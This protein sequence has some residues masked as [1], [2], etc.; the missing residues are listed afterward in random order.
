ME[1]DCKDSDSAGAKG[2]GQWCS[3]VG[4][5]AGAGW[6]AGKSRWDSFRGEQYLE[7]LE[8]LQEGQRPTERQE[9]RDAQSRLANEGRALHG[10]QPVVKRLGGRGAQ[11]NEL[12]LTRKNGI[13]SKTG[14]KGWGVDGEGGRQERNKRGRGARV[15]A[16]CG[17]GPCKGMARRYRQRMRGLKTWGW[18]VGRRGTA[19]QIRPAPSWRQGARPRRGAGR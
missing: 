6:K 5:A 7:R 18:V 11:P 9:P 14:R 8:Q 4:C 3:E 13:C 16:I 1:S 15:S 19:E 2:A 12:A 17:G 10:M